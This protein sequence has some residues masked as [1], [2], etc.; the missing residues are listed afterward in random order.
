M[1]KTRTRR[2]AS[3]YC[4]AIL[5]PMLLAL[6]GACTRQGGSAADTKILHVAVNTDIKGLDP[7]DSS[8][9]YV[10]TVLAMIYEPLFQ[11]AYL[12][13]P[14]ALEPCLAAAMPKVSADGKTYEFEIKSGV[15]FSDDAAF[16]ENGGK[17]RELKAD[18]V[19]YG[20]KRLADPKLKSTGWWLFDGRI[21]GLN[22]FRSANEKLATTDYNLVVEGLQAT[23][24]YTLRMILN[25]PY[26]Q[27]LYA[28]AM[29]FSSA[30][31]HEVVDHYG[32]EFLNHPVGTG[33]FMLKR[34][35]RS[36]QV[37]LVRNPSYRDERYPSASEAEPEDAGRGLLT[38]TGQKL[39]F[40]DGVTLHIY[41]EGN[42]RWLNFLQGNLDLSEI[43]KDNYDSA[44][45]KNG[46]LKS[47]LADKG[48]R[49]WKQ[50]ELDLTFTAFNM[51][52]PLLGKN[53]DLRRALSLAVDNPR[54]IDIM[55]NGRAL[56][57][58]GPIP[59][60]LNGYDPDFK[61]PYLTHDRE[62]AKQLL[63]RAGYPGGK[64]LPELKME[65]IDSSTQRQ[66][67]ELF[68]AE[69]HAIGVK[70][71]FNTNTW[72]E[73]T[74]KIGKRQA[75]IF[76]MGWGADYP[77]AENLLALFYSRNA[78]PG[79]NHA[80]YKNAEYDRLYEKTRIMADTPERTEI[81]KHMV[82]I[83]SEDVP[84]IFHSHRLRF[85]LYQGW[86][87]NYKPHQMRHGFVKYYDIDLNKKRELK[88]KLR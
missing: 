58:Q 19:V 69:L 67:D 73:M 39:P 55:Y 60:G 38:A 49:L 78:S 76:G 83:L 28:L 1:S 42:P 52:D 5:L 68:A 18:D 24:P 25:E 57:A 20:I 27:L 15:H 13:R 33:P 71:R 59:P 79:I 51:D 85:A 6:L 46:E 23:G 9:L 61:N 45:E 66:F 62:K 70:L 82:K 30:V 14:L 54:M 2:R 26:P 48:M 4:H 44:I 80:N 34:W 3:N 21:K 65:T 41:R 43:P 84:M 64:G 16:K 74:A 7:A 11:Y 10:N 63:A 56:P 8:D 86:L 72:P 29:P 53:A 87:L 37:E 12:K 47:A 31:A 81:Y 88:A 35:S 40:L 50:T 36:L 17:G 22:E 77:D 32:L 75:A